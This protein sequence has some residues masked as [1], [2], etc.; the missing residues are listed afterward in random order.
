MYGNTHAHSHKGKE[1]RTIKTVLN[2]KRTSGNFT[3]P[4]FNLL[5]GI[6]ILIKQHVFDNNKQTNKKTDLSIN[7]I[8]VLTNTYIYALKNS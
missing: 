3:I 5:K 4:D 6:Y 7:G 8:E 1:N 2:N